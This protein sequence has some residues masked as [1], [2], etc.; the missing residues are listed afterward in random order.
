MSSDNIF[1]KVLKDA[2]NIQDSLMGP[3]Y[4][5]YQN[6]K[7]PS[8]IGMSDNGTLQALGQDING[9]IQYVEL[10]VSGNSNASKTGGPLGNKFFLQTGQKCRAVDTNQ[11]VDRYIY[12]NNVPQGNIPIISQGLGVNFTDFKG[13]IPGTLSNLNVLNPYAIM[14]SFLSGSVPNCQQI[15]MQ[16]IDVNNNVSSQTHYVTLV[17]I[18]NMDPCNFPNG[19][20]P[21]RT[22]DSANCKETFTNINN[23]NFDN[24]GNINDFNANVE[25]LFPKNLMGQLYLASLG[26]LGLYILY[27]LIKKSK[28]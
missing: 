7:S 27:N 23:Q 3:S 26:G 2:N 9:L 14:Q 5:Y 22:G 13:L 18:Q 17:D 28:Y 4:P 19:K 16:T 11:Q 25:E 21:L 20:N 8:E 12:I 6:I 15:T 24:Y 10:L 1:T